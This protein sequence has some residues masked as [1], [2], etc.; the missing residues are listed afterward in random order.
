M[1]AF[2]RDDD[3]QYLDTGMCVFFWK[4]FISMKYFV[5]SR[6]KKF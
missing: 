6:H 5:D 1:I 4:L 3:V 2:H